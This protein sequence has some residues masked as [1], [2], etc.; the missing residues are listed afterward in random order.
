MNSYTLNSFEGPLASTKQ[1]MFIVGLR[2]LG[3]ILA[4]LIYSV[5][6]MDLITDTQGLVAFTVLLLG[7]L[8]VEIRKLW[9]LDTR[10]FWINPVV[11][12]SLF[13]FVLGF[14]V[15]NVIY[16]MPEDV[17]AL[18]GL[19]PI[20]T[21]WMNKLM[22]LVVLGAC[23]MWIGYSSNLGRN[24]GLMLQQNRMLCKWMSP[25]AR[26]NK[27]VLYA[28]LA[29][30]LIARLLEIN[31][32][33]YGYSATYDQ[34]IAGANYKQY[35]S[36]AESLGELALVGVAM[37]CFATPFSSHS[38]RQLL[39]LVTG[40]EVFF[41]FLSG[42]KSA[43]II[44]LVI[45]GVVSYS[46]RNR[47]PR[48]LIPAVLVGLIAAYAVIEPFR[49]ARNEDAGFAGTN[50]SSIVATMSSADRISADDGGE[51]VSTWLSVL[52][53]TNLTYIASLGIEYASE[54]TL[55]DG[56]PEFLKNIILAPV[57]AFIPRF[58]WDTKPLQI[59][60]L[61]YTNEVMGLDFYSSTGMSPFTYLNFAGGFLA[62]VLG[63]LF[64]GFL[65][66]G[67]FDG[68]RHFGVGGLIVLFGLLNTLVNI[69][70][71]YNTFLVGII[72]FLPILVI[73]QYMLLKRPGR[74]QRGIAIAQKR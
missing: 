55:P 44:P 16:F 26:I 17:V 27:P 42:F 8:Y 15:T 53:R 51:N 45:V 50:L 11:L 10:L 32:G 19:Q 48:W 33:V 3:A 29:I 37:Q 64:V 66:R 28:F 62:V 31:L 21:P 2:V 20:A 25:S 74:P 6:A 30:S 4:L 43:V 14:G 36:M 69:D 71:S 70:S 73:A 54:N 68:M 22:L 41:G 38:D 12:A 40:Y 61:W 63:F 9:V 65:Q 24:F 59:D 46:Q 5:L 35:L 18:V 1:G 39:W 23:A 58:L 49:V 60:G 72:R 57:H 67:L 56:S 7:Y 34:L 47:F 13:T 52:S